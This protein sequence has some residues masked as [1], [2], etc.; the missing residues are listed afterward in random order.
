M[1]AMDEFRRYAHE[2]LAAAAMAATE[3]EREALLEMAR[4]WT[5]AADRLA[6]TAGT[7]ST[8]E[9]QQLHQRR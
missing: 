6:L 5:E 7:P 4:I 9:Q 2:C 8:P 1:A 3:T